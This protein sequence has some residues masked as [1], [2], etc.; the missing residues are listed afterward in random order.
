LG[1]LF[2]NLIPFCSVPQDEE[3]DDPYDRGGRR[4]MDQRRFQQ[5]LEAERGAERRI[6]NAKRVLPCFHLVGFRFNGLV[7]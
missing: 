5:Q 6:L 2:V 3:G 7:L 4:Q 1:P